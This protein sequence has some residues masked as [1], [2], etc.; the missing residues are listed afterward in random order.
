VVVLSVP[1]AAIPEAI[2]Q[3]GSLEGRVVIDT[4]NQFTADGLLELPDHQTVA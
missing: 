3:A 4:T 1:W 2:D